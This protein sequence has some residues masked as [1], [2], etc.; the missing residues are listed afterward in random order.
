MTNIRTLDWARKAYLAKIPLVPR[1]LGRVTRL[2]YSCEIPYTA[3]IDPTVVFA[4]RGLGVVIGHDT[5]IG[6]RT[7]VLQN[8]TIGGR[9]GV[10]ANPRIGNAVLIG[11]GA[12]ILGDVKV[13]DGAQIAAHAVVLTDVPPGATAAGVPARIVAPRV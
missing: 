3:A 9:S 12:A 6:A 4:H 10:R 11:A 5:Q 7:R 2:F 1:I 8:V 13:G